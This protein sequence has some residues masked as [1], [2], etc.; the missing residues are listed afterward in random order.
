MSAQELLPL[1]KQRSKKS[2]A[3]VHKLPQSHPCHLLYRTSSSKLRFQFKAKMANNNNKEEEP[4]TAPRTDRWY[5]L[6]LGSSFK[7]QSSAKFCTLRCKYLI[8][9]RNIIYVYTKFFSKFLNLL[10]DA[11]VFLDEF[12]PFL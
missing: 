6:S 9:K 1:S 8:N 7:N 4:S 11:S 2:S 10:F 5:N 12:L 3:L